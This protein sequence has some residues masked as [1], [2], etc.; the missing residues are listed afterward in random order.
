MTSTLSRQKQDRLAYLALY[1]AIIGDTPRSE[2]ILRTARRMVRKA[3]HSAPK[4]EPVL[5]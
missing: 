1:Y 3:P 4:A 5:A 2:Q